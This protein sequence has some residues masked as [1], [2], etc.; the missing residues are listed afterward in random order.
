MSLIINS[1]GK[2]TSIKGGTISIING[3]VFADGAEVKDLTPSRRKNINITIQGDVERLEVEYC[4][5]I[6]VTGNAKRV[7][8]LNGD[9]EIKGDVDGDVHTNCGS[10]TCGNVEGDCHT[11]M[12]NISKRG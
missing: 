10:I 12:G 7:H 8:T 11:N 5:T 9:I 2:V 3:K 6:S 1:N 4:N